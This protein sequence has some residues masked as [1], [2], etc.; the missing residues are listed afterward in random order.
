[1][2]DRCATKSA[3]AALKP[4]T[5]NAATYGKDRKNELMAVNNA[6]FV[7]VMVVI[8]KM[9]MG[10]IDDDSDSVFLSR[11]TP[12]ANGNTVFTIFVSPPGVCLLVLTS[13]GVPFEDDDDDDVCKT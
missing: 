8:V 7:F 5:V 11:I 2:A 1:M 10:D 3:R 6:S 12:A 9:S 13:L 4:H